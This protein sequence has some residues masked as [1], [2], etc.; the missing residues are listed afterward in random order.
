MVT[1]FAK[2]FGLVRRVFAE[3]FERNCRHCTQESTPEGEETAQACENADCNSWL[4]LTLRARVQ[5]PAMPIRP[6]RL[7][8]R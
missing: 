2:D 6:P 4:N 7:H 5:R 1:L 8:C 3:E